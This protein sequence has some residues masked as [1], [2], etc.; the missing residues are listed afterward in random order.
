MLWFLINDG[1]IVLLWKW[2]SNSCNISLL[3]RGHLL[4]RYDH[5]L[6]KDLML[7]SHYLFVSLDLFILR[8]FFVLLGL[9]I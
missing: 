3:F 4:F 1:E 8:F 6:D 9:K 5:L 2:R 7:F